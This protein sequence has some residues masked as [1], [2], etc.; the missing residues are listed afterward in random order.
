MKRAEGLLEREELAEGE[1]LCQKEWQKDTGDPRAGFGLGLIAQARGQGEAAEKYLT[2]ARKSPTVCKQATAQLAA[3]ARSRGDVQ[4]AAG[5]EQEFA[6]LPDEAPP[7][8]DPLVME[9]LRRRVDTSASAQVL[10]QLEAQHRY[11]EA[12]NVYIQQL[13]EHPTAQNYVGAGLNTVY[14]RPTHLGLHILPHSIP[15]HS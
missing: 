1:E 4:A 3:L 12:A 6:T 8:P 11:Q 15:T 14:S 9:L 2:A 13:K 7:W 5:L 10:A